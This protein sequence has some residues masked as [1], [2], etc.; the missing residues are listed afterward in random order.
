MH[1]YAV[2]LKVRV[3]L[4]LK[5]RQKLAFVNILYLIQV[6]NPMWRRGSQMSEFCLMMIAY[7]VWISI[8]GGVSKGGGGLLP[9]GLPCLVVTSPMLP[10]C[11]KSYFISLGKVVK[12]SKASAG[13]NNLLLGKETCRN[14]WYWSQN[15]QDCTRFF[16]F[17]CLS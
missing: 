3:R 5:L 8:R 7:G 15:Q 1:T 12:L 6:T 4:K 17:F 14:Y 9:A 16:F 13:H 11:D 10:Y 2:L